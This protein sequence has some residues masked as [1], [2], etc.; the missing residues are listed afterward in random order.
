VPIVRLPRLSAAFATQLR[1]EWK[2]RFCHQRE[3]DGA[4]HIRT[5]LTPSENI[6]PKLS[7]AHLTV[8]PA[9]PLE[10]I[11][12]AEAAGFDAVGLRICP[13][14]PGDTITPVVGD[15]PLQRE[16]KQRLS[17]TGISIMD[18]EAF[19]LMPDTS[20]DHLMP[21]FEV[22]AALGARNILVVGNDPE[23][24][25]LIDRFGAF[26]KACA[27]F[28]LRPML[29]FIPYSQ[30][31]SLKD[32]HDVLT[33]SGAAN[34]GVLVDALHLSRSGGS[35]A[36]IKH[37]PPDLFTYVHL[38]DAPG[39]PPAADAIRSEARGGRSYPGEG[40]LWLEEFVMAF[41]EG[42]PLAVEAPSAQHGQLPLAGQAE[43][44]ARLTRELLEK[45]ARDDRRR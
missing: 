6:V 30:I 28:G 25:R 16:L 8:L 36:D 20:I 12:L 14:L 19:W 17:Q 38:C 37:Y 3:R 24:A 13:P 21:S 1:L 32:A 41:P 42:T 33:V 26:C 4:S 44:A 35:P 7:L 10:L 31:R 43:L 5:S 11:D 40:G 22:G 9:K 2:P 45:I 27:G 34:A 23:R 15:I 29:E 39:L 18:V